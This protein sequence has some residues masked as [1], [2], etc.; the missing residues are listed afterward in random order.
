MTDAARIAVLSDIHGNLPALEAVLAEVESVGVDLLV[1]NGDLA[2]GPFPVETLDL[3]HSLGDRAVWV[4][5]NGDRWL[6]E[7]FDGVFRPTGGPADELIEW[8][9]GMLSRE[10]RDLLAAASLTVSFDDVPGLGSVGF[11]HATARDDNEMVLVDST[12]D[13]FREA[14]AASEEE[15]MVVGHCHMPFDRLFDRRRIV[16]A[17][18]VGMPYGHTG[19][20]WA[21]LGNQMTLRRTGYDADAAAELMSGTGM[22]DLRAFLDENICETPSDT[23]AM[24]V[25]SKVREKQLRARSS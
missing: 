11:C 10:H 16:N 14:F 2:D 6:V 17:G 15:T 4:R 8:A 21:L 25:F 3:L 23:E 5:G 13:H 19:A 20:S 24:D 12:I 18:S 9:A 7:A 22:P 1:L